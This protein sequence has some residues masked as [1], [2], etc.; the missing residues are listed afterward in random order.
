MNEL[1][2]FLLEEQNKALKK[3]AETVKGAEYENIESR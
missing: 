2:N 3:L 1:L